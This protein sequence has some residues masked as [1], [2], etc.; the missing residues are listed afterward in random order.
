[1]N[2]RVKWIAGLMA[3]VIFSSIGFVQESKA[4]VGNLPSAN[5]GTFSTFVFAGTSTTK[6]ICNTNS[7]ADALTTTT[8]TLN[9]G[10]VIYGWKIQANTGTNA[11]AAIV[12][13]ADIINVDGSAESTNIVDE[14]GEPTQYDTA[15]DGWPGPVRLQNGFCLT[16]D[17]GPVV[18]IYYS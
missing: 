3:L 7:V 12:D 2:K 17:G 14:L 13:V 6:N 16:T 5:V 9:A 11:T 8:T 18:T 1:M 10:N 15:T 4:A